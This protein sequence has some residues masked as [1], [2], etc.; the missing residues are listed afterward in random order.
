MSRT[1]PASILT[2]LSQPE[3]QPFYAV[4]FMFDNAPIRFWTGYGDRTIE[5]NTYTG[6][7]DLMSI[8]GLEEVSDMSAKSAS[9]T[10]NGIPP[11]LISLALQEEY[12][13]RE[14]RILFGVT[15]SSDIVEVFAGTMDRM[16]IQDGGETGT[17]D[18]TVESKWVRLDRA[19]VRRY[20]SESQKS[21][22]STDT[23]FDYVADLQDKDVVW[24]RKSD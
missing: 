3:V 24:G 18:L 13:N 6:T 5:T 8:G 12:Q 23:F 19:N 17:I 21:R 10:L 20:T 15:D 7:G 2:A 4:E 16:T 22:H 11:T 1:V 9:I 14:C